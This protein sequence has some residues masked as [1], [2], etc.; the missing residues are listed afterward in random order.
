MKFQNPVPAVA[1]CGSA[2]NNPVCAGGGVPFVFGPSLRSFENNDT[3][4]R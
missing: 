3:H 1:G 2:R 4:H